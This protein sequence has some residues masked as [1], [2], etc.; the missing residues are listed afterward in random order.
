MQAGIRSLIV[1]DLARVGS[2]TGIGTEALCQRLA[3][4][5]PDVEIVAGGGVRGVADLLRLKEIGV[6]GV[7]V[8]SALH[9]GRLR[10]ADLDGL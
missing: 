2:G 5:H 9:D 4:C 10:R 8:A 1:L 3:A 6:H 7:L